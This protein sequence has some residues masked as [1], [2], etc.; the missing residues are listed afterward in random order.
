MGLEKSFISSRFYFVAAFLLLLIFGIL[1][2]LTNIQLV[3]GEYYRKLAAQKTIQTHTIAAN[4]GNIYSSD[5]SLLA[6]SI[7]KYTIRFDAV[8]PSKKDFDEH[9]SP[10]ADSLANLLGKESVYYRN[11]LIKSR[12]NKNRYLPIASKLNYADFMR[13]KKFP[14]FK[15]GPYKGGLI[16]EQSSEREY[17]T[18]MIAQRTIGYDKLDATGIRTGK[19]IEWSF[20]EYLTGNDGKQL[21]QKMAKGQWKPIRDENLIEPKDGLD[22]HTTLNIHIQDIAHHAL[23]E[24]LNYYEADHG[25]VVVME[26]KTGHIKAISNLGRNKNGAY[27]ERLNYAVQETF[28]PGSTFKLLSLMALLEDNVA[29]TSSVFDS[30]DGQIKIYNEFINDSKKGGYGKISLAKAFEVS[31]NTVIVSAVNQHYKNNP[32]KFINHIHKAGLHQPLD[33]QLRGA[34]MPYIP[35]PDDK[36]NWSGLSLPW[37]SWGYGILLSPLHTLTFYN[38][39]AN[40]GVMVKPQFVEEIK[41]WNKS[42]KKFEPEIINER[43]C[44]QETI[45]KLKPLLENVVKKG[46]AT[47]LYSKNLPLAG[48]TGTTKNAYQA[49]N[50]HYVSS[51]VGYFPANEPKYSCIVVVNKPNEKY[52]V[53]GADVS[54]P[55]F[56]KIAQKIYVNSPQKNIVSD[57]IKPKNIEKNYNKYYTS[58]QENIMPNLVGFEMMDAMS[59]AENMGIKVKINGIGK[60]KKQSIASGSK[61]NTN[62]ILYLEAS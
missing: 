58:F 18:G 6:T 61:I 40:D 25:C 30:N 48:K 41:D 53:Y 31:S 19:G 52:G 24:Q 37:M 9:L 35:S 26:I 57:S 47:N 11:L 13:L 51:F 5:G 14:L 12:T 4:R 16:V 59:I 49:D 28:E 32:K 27:V 60:V 56:K 36:K 45:N 22:L 46:T 42:V 21:M 38:A 39:I 20:R 23:L 43:V 7:Q 44:S 1:I 8:S 15:K 34:A 17:P 50:K 2:K 62:Q 55:V 54:G 33:L 29:D 3:E 10:L